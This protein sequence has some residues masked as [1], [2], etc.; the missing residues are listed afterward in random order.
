VP[1]AGASRLLPRGLC[2]QRSG[3]SLAAIKKWI[4]DKYKGKLAE[5]YERQVTAAIKKLVVSGELKKV[6]PGGSGRVGLAVPC[7]R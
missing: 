1:K 4:A 6:G 7:G 5:G 2:T 3:S